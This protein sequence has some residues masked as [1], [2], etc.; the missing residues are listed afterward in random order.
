MRTVLT[1]GA[2]GNIGRKLRAH[3]YDDERTTFGVYNLVSNNPE[4]RCETGCVMSGCAAWARGSPA[5]V[6]SSAYDAEEP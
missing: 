1:A 2:V 4:M 6:G 3:F 5:R